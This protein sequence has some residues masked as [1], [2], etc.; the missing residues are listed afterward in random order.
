VQT[1]TPIEVRIHDLARGGAGVGR[2]PTGEIIF[3]PFTAPGDLVRVRIL[4]RKKSY[5]HGEL[6]E[7]IEASPGRVPPPCPAFGRC[8]GCSWQHIPYPLQFETKVKG[9]HSALTRAGLESRSLPIDLLPAEETY[10]YRNRIQIR[11]NPATREAGFYRPGTH[12]L[13]PV[14]ECAIADPK[15]NSALG[16]LLEEGFSRFTEPFKLEI[17]LTPEGG[18]RADWN[19]RH[20]ATGF[21]QINDRQNRALQS[22][23]KVHAGTGDLLLDLYGG[24]GNLS[25]PLL[26][27]FK[28]I[29]C[30]DTGAP[31]EE[32]PAPDFVFIRKSLQSWCGAE[33]ARPPS[34]PAV[35]LLDPPRE[36]IGDLFPKLEARLSALGV[37]RVILVGCDVDAFA[38]DA[39]RFAAARYRLARLATL[40]LF[41]QTPHLESL[42]LFL[43]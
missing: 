35:A 5:I 26:G 14:S 21:Q 31:E 37:S 25:L 20:A 1:D 28:R 11:G 13:V 22:W 2:L 19:E 23:V 9:L 29:V 36:G 39:S 34:G 30:V 16:K 10:H 4:E 40:D 42:A 33:D 8:G 32:G 41:P 6:V 12:S 38:R 43:K 17:S 15:I 18:V 7:V 27:D 24:N 3:V